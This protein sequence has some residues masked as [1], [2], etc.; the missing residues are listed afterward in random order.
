[1]TAMLLPLGMR[2]T[3]FVEPNSARNL[4]FGSVKFDNRKAI[5]KC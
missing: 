4:V 2:S 5:K 1:M 3:V